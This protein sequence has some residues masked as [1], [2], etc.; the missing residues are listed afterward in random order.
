MRVNPDERIPSFIF[1]QI[2]YYL[3]ILKQKSDSNQES[4]QKLSGYQQIKLIKFEIIKLNY[5]QNI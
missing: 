4:L 2:S 5:F 1:K 3:L